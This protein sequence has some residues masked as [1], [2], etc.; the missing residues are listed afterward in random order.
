MPF[1]MLRINQFRPLHQH[2]I[3]LDL[4]FLIA[5]RRLLTQVGRR[6]VEIPK[7]CPVNL[8][9]SLHSD[10]PISNS[11]PTESN[12]ARPISPT[13]NGSAAFNASVTALA[14]TSNHLADR[15]LAEPTSDTDN[16]RT[17][18]SNATTVKSTASATKGATQTDTPSR[19][20]NASTDRRPALPWT[21]SMAVR[22]DQSRI[23]RTSLPTALL[24]SMAASA[25][26]ESLKTYVPPI[27]GRIAPASS[28]GS[29]SAHWPRR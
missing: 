23:R 29:T 2:W 20:A 3:E 6:R 21:I 27:W 8:S 1:A 16:R 10:Q 12:N 13:I 22:A 4:P 15:T 24:S 5:L 25:V 26:R 14:P 7:G 18:T 9:K 17:A 19:S 28:F 11:G